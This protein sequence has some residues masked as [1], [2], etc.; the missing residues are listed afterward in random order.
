M[1]QDLIFHV[2]AF[3]QMVYVVTEEE[4]RFITQFRAKYGDEQAK[5]TW[6]F[7]AAL[8]LIPVD[9]LITDW[10]TR[11]HAESKEDSTINDALIRIYRDDPKNEKNV[12]IIT[13]PDRWLREEMVQRRV[14]NIA[15]QLHNNPKVIKTLLFVGPRKL[16]PE[17]LARYIE[18]VHDTGLPPEE[19]LEAVTSLCTT[20]KTAVPK[21]AVKVF[22]G[23]THYE[24][25]SAITQSFIKTKQD[26]VNPRRV[27]PVVI[28]EYK[29]HQLRKT[30]LLQYVNTENCTFTDV[31]GAQGFK[32]WALET[33]AAWTAEGQAF[34]LKPPKGVLAMGVW[35]CGKS[36]SVKALGNAWGLPVVQM[37][38]G[39]LRSSGVGESEANVYRAC[40]LIENVAPC[41][42]FI[43]ESEKSLSGNASSG[44]SDAGT[45]SR[46]I[47]ILSTW[48]Q[49]TTAPICMAMTANSVATLPIEFINRMDERFF[50]DLPNE[51]ER[52]EILK[53][54]IR[55]VGQDPSAF[56][57]AE[58]A[59]KAKNM[60]GREIEQAIG[61]AMVKSFQAKCPKLDEAILESVLNSKPRIFKTMGDELKELINW[62]GLDP[63]T[64]E[65]IRARFA[66]GLP[67]D[68][69]KLITT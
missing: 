53:I 31:G 51:D 26:S 11:S 62:V 44:V 27:D 10:E 19:L 33:K 42:V 21:D 60:V 13:D 41:L 48:L 22:N 32:D 65:G 4:D 12:Y 52:I 14:L 50:F 43:D 9:Q 40:R 18:V 24:V 69:L 8:G 68:T 15:H 36:L 61:A 59:E 1:N 66:S 35:G 58:L 39:K 56:N 28:A 17:K 37:E 49:E 67:S 45:T 3:T 6:V 20:L 54:H 30:D 29:R 46:T 57:L 16:I 5:R 25:T 64:G 23:L 38:M 63:A 47:G 55:K 2:Q 7:N 34:G